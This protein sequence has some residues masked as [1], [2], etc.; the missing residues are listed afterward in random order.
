[1]DLDTLIQ[2]SRA[3]I[4]AAHDIEEAN[5]LT[6]NLSADLAECWPDD[7]QPRTLAHVELGRDLAAQ[8]LAY[9]RQ[10]NRGPRPFAIAHWVHGMHLLS[11]HRRTADRAPLAAAIQAFD[12]SVSAAREAA[13]DSG[14]L[15]PA[16]D[17]L[18]ILNSAFAALARNLES[19]GSGDALWTAART[20]F[21]E[22]VR[23]HPTRAEEA[24]YG[25][26]NLEVAHARLT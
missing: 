12:A 17:Y 25:L 14:P 3:T 24:A 18:V 5:R 6:Y 16:S 21:E 22:Q 9:R 7:D 11:I 13:A 10:L 1:M 20:C 26:K 15:T 2:N 23:H 8:C 19:P 4:A